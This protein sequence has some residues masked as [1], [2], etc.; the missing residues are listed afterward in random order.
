MKPVYLEF[1]GVNSFSE[2]AA[3]DFAKLLEFGI[4]GIFGDTGSGKSTILD[5]VGFALY[6]TVARARAG[7]VAD[8]IHY[9][10]DEAFVRF[11]FEIFYEGR[12]RKYRVERLL[13]RKNAAQTVTVYEDCGGW[14]A[15]ASGCRES[16]AFLERVIGL[17]QRDFEKCI[18]LPQGEFAQFVKAQRGERLKLI[19]RLFDLE[20][21]GERL[22]KQV[23]RKFNEANASLQVAEARLEP[24]AE[25]S[26]ARNAELSAELEALREEGKAAKA[27]LGGAQAEEKSLA[28][29][30][31]RKT[32]AVKAEARLRE[33]E[34]IGPAMRKRGEELSRLDGA[35]AV[36]RVAREGME[37]KES[38]LAAERELEAAKARL[39]AAE[40]GL[41][42]LPAGSE[43]EAEA[44]IERLTAL[45]EKASAA[46]NSRR[47]LKRA[48]EALAETLGKEKEEGSRFVGF[49]Y[50]SLKSELVRKIGELGEG[51]FLSFAEEHGKPALFREEYAAFA[52][53]IEDLTL[54]HPE[55]GEDS[56][57]ISQKY[58]ALSQGERADFAELRRAFE[59]RERAR[60]KL[61]DDLLELERRQGNYLLHLQRLEELSK[62]AERLRGEIE[63][64]RSRL[65]EA[66]PL[67]ETVRALEAAKTA[68]R[69]RAERR[70]RLTEQLS[71]AR[72]ALAAAEEKVRGEER[73]L[74]MLR[75]RCKEALEAGG[76][77]SVAEA[78]ALA[79]RYG[80][81]VRARAEYEAY[82]NELAAVRAR[83][84]EF[85][86]ED[87]S[88]VDEQT[89]RSAQAA[90]AAAEEA[91]RAAAGR[92][93]LAESELA[94]SEKLLSEKTAL[95]ETR[96][97]AAASKNVYEQLKK[98]IEGNKFMEFVAE[99]YL[100]TIAINASGRL[101]SLTDGRY[102]LRYEKGFYVGD[103]FNG[104]NLRGVH[105]LSGGETF[106]VS[107]S[108]ALSLGA[109]ICARSMRPIEFFFLDEGF[110]TLD[111]RLV[112]TV[113]DSLERLRGENF[114]I[115]V[116]SHVE[117][118]K[119]RIDRKLTVKK[120]TEKHGSQIV[121]E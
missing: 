95:E 96:T 78:E 101:L 33:L 45:S 84:K 63:G 9:Q 22:V 34:E 3:V 112:D 54:L 100:Q 119:H 81:P 19:S 20:Q 88:G 31:A 64:L 80:D 91:V 28:A 106:L 61:S 98:L 92:T 8:I 117:E 15:V 46:E 6:G 60:R 49:S 62:T 94:R 85:E 65:A 89:L 108:L 67:A 47:D 52:Q 59:E 40:E 13:K 66:P 90:L 93:A 71:S 2:P 50:E 58:R 36:L 41:A 43:E 16:N 37:I 24:Y 1:C 14:I 32:E 55:I 7:S 42:S 79:A 114:S 5:C 120:A 115:G 116:I 69:Q 29:R 38:R 21:F 87:F 30:F 99:E 104:G 110:G 74:G 39:S 70:G 77:G 12:R 11:D 25:V 107:L 97:A 102:F 82:Q 10:K 76:F 121:N 48:E 57:P 53:E 35:A 18:A 44:E 113:M 56:R 83:R 73:A 109:E 111:E 103:N 72:A 23:N 51:D 68:K 4:F 75:K 17:E 118:L 86:G 105:T 27:A 26:A